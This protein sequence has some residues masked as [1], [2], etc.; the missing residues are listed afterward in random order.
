MAKRSHQ[1]ADSSDV[2]KDVTEISPTCRSQSE[3]LAVHTPKY[4]SLE[5]AETVETPTMRC[6]LPPHKALNFT[7]YADYEL[8]YQQNHTNRCTDCKKNFP[9]SHFLELHIAE[10][11]DPIVASKR[12]AGEKTY[13]CFVEGC[14]K[15]CGEWKKRRRHLVD[16]HG[17]PM[18]Y[19]FLV[20]DHGIDG[21]RS[22]L[23]PGVDAQG[24]RKSS[25]ERERRGSSLSEVTQTTEATSISEQNGASAQD[26]MKSGEA[27]GGEVQKPKAATDRKNAEVDQLTSSMS[28][29]KMVPRSITFGKRKGRSGFAK[30]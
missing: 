27:T 9:T 13:R 1:K 25:R 11:H 7:T 5:P 4:A 23:R 26:E 14:E 10:N 3:E 30:S 2:E 18:N 29:L 6:H 12:E 20:V 28:S 22:M 15:V 17:F 24:H 19:D 21:R 16:K 8:H